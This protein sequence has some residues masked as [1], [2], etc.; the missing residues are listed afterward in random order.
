MTRPRGTEGHDERY[1]E[2]GGIRGEA[3]DW[4]A[5]RLPP[6]LG[7]EVHGPRPVSR[8]G[9]LSTKPS[10]PSRTPL[11]RRCAGAAS[12]R[13]WARARSSSPERRSRCHR[14]DRR[15]HGDAR[16]RRAAVRRGRSH[17]HGG[18]R[19][20]VLLHGA[21]ALPR[22]P[23]R[24][25]GEGGIQSRAGESGPCRTTGEPR[26]AAAASGA[27]GRCGS[28]WLCDS[29]AS[30]GPSVPSGDTDD[31]SPADRGHPAM[32]RHRVFVSRFVA[33]RGCR[34]APGDLNGVLARLLSCRQEREPRIAVARETDG[35]WDR[36]TP[37]LSRTRRGPI[38][39]AGVSCR[40]PRGRTVRLRALLTRPRDS[41]VFP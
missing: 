24:A 33:S 37:S 25:L 1:A 20:D 29:D 32:E 5:A 17:R 8:G 27:P 11:S 41:D 34:S 38:H 26:S 40:P 9:G 23:E 31:T 18:A 21:P 2:S 39:G 15:R 36:G 4:R 16:A 12:R 22:R 10:A 35:Q 13:A 6:Q 30:S 3:R 28:I 7:R 19:D 14:R